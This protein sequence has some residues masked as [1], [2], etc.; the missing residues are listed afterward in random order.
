[1]L[2]WCVKSDASTSPLK[3]GL[4]GVLPLCFLPVG[5]YAVG[6]CVVKCMIYNDESTAKFCI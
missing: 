1:M 2:F 6:G 5:V 3:S 4:L